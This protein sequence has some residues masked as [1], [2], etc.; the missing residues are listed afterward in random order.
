MFSVERLVGIPIPFI[1]LDF[2]QIPGLDRED[3][4]LS[5]DEMEKLLENW[6]YSVSVI[7]H[8]DHEHTGHTTYWIGP[9]HTAFFAGPMTDVDQ[10]TPLAS[11][12]WTEE[13]T[14]DMKQVY[15]LLTGNYD[16]FPQ[17]QLF[18]QITEI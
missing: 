8:V 17:H 4:A 3:D 16:H 14:N 12:T 7:C 1:V 13:D 6:G 9:H 18:E 11:L 15:N 5:A 10:A 2:S